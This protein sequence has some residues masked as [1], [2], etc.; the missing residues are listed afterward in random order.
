M[1]DGPVIDRYRQAPRGAAYDPLAM[2]RYVIAAQLK[3]GKAAEAERALADGPPFDPA[4]VGL[5]GHAAYLTDERVYLLF[6]GETARS[7][8][9]QLAREHLVE[10]SRWQGIVKGLPKTVTTVPA[11]ARCIYQWAREP[12]NATG[13]GA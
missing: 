2:E 8:A 6:Q 13:T 1:P 12:S 10:V 7:T 11:E 4:Q 9:L 3:A 5:S